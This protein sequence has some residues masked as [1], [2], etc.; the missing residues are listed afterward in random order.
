[1]YIVEY[2]V[3]VLPHIPGDSPQVL[4]QVCVPRCVLF[5]GF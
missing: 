2:V 4:N 3:A 5:V 1:V